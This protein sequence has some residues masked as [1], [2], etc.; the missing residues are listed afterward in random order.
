MDIN[1]NDMLEQYGNNSEWVLLFPDMSEE[2][3]GLKYDA[4]GDVEMKDDFGDDGGG[5]GLQTPTKSRQELYEE[6]E[7]DFLFLPGEINSDNEF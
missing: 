2:A 5:H 4:D 3:T 7:N 1:M 6:D